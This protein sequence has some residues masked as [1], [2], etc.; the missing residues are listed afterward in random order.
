[1]QKKLIHFFPL[2]YNSSIVINKFRFHFI[3]LRFQSIAF[4]SCFVH[5]LQLHHHHHHCCRHHRQHHHHYEQDHLH[6]RGFQRLGQCRKKINSPSI[7]SGNWSKFCVCTLGLKASRH[8]SCVIS[9][10][11]IIPLCSIWLM[12]E[13]LLNSCRHYLLLQLRSWLLSFSFAEV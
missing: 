2:L 13:K 1:M 12:L 8:D 4:F 5:Q 11:G 10:I 6:R 9:A 7:F 3:S